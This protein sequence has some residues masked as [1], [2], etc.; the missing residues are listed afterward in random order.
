MIIDEYFF[1]F[2]DVTID[3]STS[4]LVSIL[5]TYISFVIQI[6]DH[7]TNDCKTFSLNLRIVKNRSNTAMS[8][9]RQSTIA[10]DRDSNSD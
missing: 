3:V 7:A 4:I 9:E 10:C 8:C 1:I 5:T 6:D 2:I